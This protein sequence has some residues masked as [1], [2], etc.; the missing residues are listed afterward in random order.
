MRFI[1][2]VPQPK[3]R[4]HKL[5]PIEAPSRSRRRRRGASIATYARLHLIP[6]ESCPNYRSHRYVPTDFA[7][8][9]KNLQCDVTNGLLL[10]III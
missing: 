2:A 7:E 8:E 3:S 9:A 4:R 10:Q 6:I 5:K 1:T